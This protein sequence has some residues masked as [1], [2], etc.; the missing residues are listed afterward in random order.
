MKEALEDMVYQFGYR[1][2][3]DGKPCITTGGLSALENAFEVLGWDDPY[4]VKE[5]GNTCEIKGCMVES[6]SGLNWGRLYLRLC[7]KHGRM[8]WQK[9]RRPPVKQYALE[10][11]SKR[12]KKT[13]WLI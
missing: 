11:E 7:S 12:D 3:V 5:E 10:R 1:D 13:G 2:V 6:S 4:F 9:K 8:A